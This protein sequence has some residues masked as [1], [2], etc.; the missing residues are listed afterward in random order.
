MKKVI[1]NIMG[2]AGPLYDV[3]CFQIFFVP[4]LVVVHTFLLSLLS[5]S[6]LELL[7]LHRLDVALGCHVSS[8]VQNVS[9]LDFGQNVSRLDFGHQK[10]ASDMNL[11]HSST[12]PSPGVYTSDE[13]CHAMVPRVILCEMMVR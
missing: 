7:D 9:R 8:G 2:G 1:P 5:L 11:T 3:F 12:G 10:F 13:R 4:V 6:S